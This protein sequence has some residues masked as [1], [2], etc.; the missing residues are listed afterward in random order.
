[1]ILLFAIALSAFYSGLLIQRCMDFDSNI[2]TY[3]DI[4]ERAFGNI[5]R[6]VVSIVMYTELYL[7][8]AGFLILEGDN[9]HNFFQTVEIGIGGLSIGG[10]QCFV[11]LVALVILPSVW[12]DNLSLLS[13]VSASGVLASAVILGSILWTGP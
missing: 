9:L 4:G 1:M 5:G 11:I 13:Y 10:M 8:A 2:R 7:V 6:V 12:L 3:P